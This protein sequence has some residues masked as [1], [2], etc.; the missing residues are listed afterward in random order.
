MA[1]DAA[2]FTLPWM[3][4]HPAVWAPTDPPNATTDKANATAKM[5]SAATMRG[6]DTEFEPR[7]ITQN[8]SW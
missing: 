1:P 5:V 6:D 8:L 7:G 3:V 2:V 4:P